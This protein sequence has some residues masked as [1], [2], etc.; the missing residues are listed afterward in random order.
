MT[1]CFLGKHTHAQRALKRHHCEHHCANY[2]GTERTNLS[3]F[4][5]PLFL[6]PHFANGFLSRNRSIQTTVAHIWQCVL[7]C[8]AAVLTTSINTLTVVQLQGSQFSVHLPS[9]SAWEGRDR[10]ETLLTLGKS[11]TNSAKCAIVLDWPPLLAGNCQGPS[12]HT[13][14]HTQCA[15]ALLAF[16]VFRRRH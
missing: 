9:Y 4:I 3:F 12:P 16:C 11:W 13:H 15:D 5:F 10:V 7:V 2:L 1:A 6:V 14:T 8:A